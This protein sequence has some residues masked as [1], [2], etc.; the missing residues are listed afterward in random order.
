MNTEVKLALTEEAD[1]ALL[2]AGGSSSVVSS[3]VGELRQG[4]LPDKGLRT[5]RTSS[6]TPCSG[7]KV[8]TIPS[9][10]TLVSLRRH[11]EALFPGQLTLTRMRMKRLFTTQGMSWLPMK[12]TV[13]H[14]LLNMRR[15]DPVMMKAHLIRFQPVKA[16]APFLRPC[17]HLFTK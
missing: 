12:T 7:A 9:S 3:E 10:F 8:R 4:T 11:L 16:P 17:P 15:P 13:D 1:A 6:C 5:T 2:D 14:D